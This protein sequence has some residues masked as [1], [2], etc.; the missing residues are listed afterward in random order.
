[1]RLKYNGLKGFTLIEILIALTIIAIALAA[2]MR[3]L[4]LSTEAAVETKTRTLATW[5][6]QNR[7]ALALALVLTQG[8]L[9]AIATT[10][11]TVEMAGQQFKVDETVAESP[12]KAFRKFSVKV[13]AKQANVDDPNARSL[14]SLEAYLTQTG[15]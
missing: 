11:N 9:P 5:V 12:N 14:I 10:Q 6:A 13:S 7:V 2:S 15:Q 3:G 8:T 1:M 4:A